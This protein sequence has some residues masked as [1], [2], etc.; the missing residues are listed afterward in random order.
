MKNI[1]KFN[2]VYITICK[3]NGKCY[4]GSHCTNNAKLDDGKYFGSGRAFSNAISKYTKKNFHRIILKHCENIIDARNLEGYYINMFDTIRPNG[5]N[6]S[7][8]GGMDRGMFGSHS[9]ETKKIL[10]DKRTGKAPWNK[11]RKNIYSS[12]TLEL[13]S[14]NAKQRIGSKNPN[15][16]NTGIKSPLF[17]KKFSISH[18]ANIKNAKL[19]S[20]NPNAKTYEI[21]TPDNKKIISLSAADFVRNYPEYGINR[22]FI[23]IA[24]SKDSYKNWK[25]KI[26]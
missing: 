21:I 23:Y 25:V 19:G 6:I 12:E 8:S 4:V 14:Q 18:K 13:M 26:L 10:S 1:K 15:Y 24:S 5:Y 11:G 9:E 3:I 17:G 16:G 20:K 7:P 2:F 22:Y